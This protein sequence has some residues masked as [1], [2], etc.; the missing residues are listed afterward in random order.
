VP[1]WNVS[2]INFDIW[3]LGGTLYIPVKNYQRMAMF[4]A[5]WGLSQRYCPGLKLTEM[6]R[7]DNAPQAHS[8]VSNI[9]FDICI[10]GRP[11]AYPM[12]N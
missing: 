9:N 1:R 5:N 7:W 4:F 10:G 6:P 11:Y 8:R 2:N 3:I 12:N